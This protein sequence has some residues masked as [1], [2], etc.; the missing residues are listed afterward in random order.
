M[1]LLR[2]SADFGSVLLG[3]VTDSPR[4]TRIRVQILLTASIVVPN[5][6]GA[7]VSVVLT[8]VGIP[9]PSVFGREFWWINYVAV[10]VYIGASLL[11]GVVIGTSLGLRQL[12][13]A[14]A[15]R[16]PTAKQARSI[17]WMPLKFTALQAMF[18][19]GG[20]ALF[21]TSY[22]VTD[23]ELIPKIFFVV[24]FSG[25]VVCAT[26]YLLVEFALRPIAA[27]VI[28]ATMTRRRRR[29]AL[30]TRALVS[31]MVGSGIPVVG[32]FLVV[33][34]SLARSQTTKT[35]VFIGV[36]VLVGISLLTGLLLTVLNTSHL[37]HPIR[38]VRS[39]MA[40]VREGRLDDVALVIY[41]DTELGELQAGFNAMVAGLQ[42]R[43]RLRDLFGRHVGREV[44]EAAEDADPELG[45]AERTVAVMFVDVIGSTTLAA[46]RSPSEVVGILNRFFAVI[47]GE[48][49]RNRGL[50]NKF[51]GDAVLAVF[52]APTEI[53]DPAGAALAA[54]RTTSTRL[55]A[56]VP[57]LSA[58]IGVSF[59]RVVAGYVGAIERFEYTVIGDAVNESARLSEVAKRDPR[60][61]LA[62]GAAITAARSERANWTPDGALLLRGRTQE[63]NIFAVNIVTT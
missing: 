3:S 62:S 57:E 52:G 36:T 49:E 45:G 29:S 13:W 59:G 60:R 47:V 15:R 6:I 42:E 14:I 61:P 26:S 7:I 53:D 54:A 58:G 31:W 23:P 37:L 51:E 2:R 32:I 38:A 25:T 55:T 22:G 17:R 8:T 5:A 43:E 16:E 40:Q 34:F 18:W 20:V 44:A 4:V 46:T 9:Q 21:T 35:D 63:T 33:I 39:G 24:M 27:Q 28:N 48:V 12:R 10:P 1:G 41:D 11:I 56:E 19:I 30:R 50:V